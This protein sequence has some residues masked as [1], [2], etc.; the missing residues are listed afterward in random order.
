MYN[1]D[2]V[3]KEKFFRQRK[4]LAWRTPIICNA[5]MNV[6]NPTSVVDFGC[7]NGDLIGELSKQPSITSTLA[8]EGTQNSLESI[9]SNYKGPLIIHDLRT[10][11]VAPIRKFDLALCLEVAEHL[12]DEYAHVLTRSL[13]Q[14]SNTILFSAAGPDQGGIGHVNCRPFEYW[15]YK[16]MAFGFVRNINLTKLFNDSLLPWRTKKGIK[17]YF[18]NAVVFVRGRVYNEQ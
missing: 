15:F 14:S 16:F 9:Q 5:I 6:F 12:E 3:Y 8:V 17:A 7:G 1:I 13:T 4:S 2:A 18:Q 11:L 10:P